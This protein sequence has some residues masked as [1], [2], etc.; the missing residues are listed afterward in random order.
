MD[1]R[2]TTIATLCLL[3]LSGATAHAAPR[4]DGQLEINVVDKDSGQPIAARV[5]LQNARKRPVQLNLPNT[6]E[7][8]DHFYI[9]G[10]LTLPMHRGQY[11]FEIDAGPEYRTQAGHFE[12]ERHADDVKQIKMTRFADLAKE[13]WFA[14]DLDFERKPHDLPLIFRAEHLQDVRSVDFARLLSD[15]PERSAI[16]NPKSE[17]QIAPTPFAWRL[18]AWLASGELDAI[19]LIHRHSLREKVVDNEGDGRPRDRDLFPGRAGNGRWS[20]T[21]YYH[22]LNCGLRMPPVAG[23]GSGFNDSPVGMNRVYVYC[24]EEFS[25]EAWWDGLREGRVFVTNG[26]LLRPSVDG[27]APGYVFHIDDEERLSLEIG[28]NL[29]TRLPVEYLEI[30]QNGELYTDVRL[31][32]W[33]QKKDRLPPVEFDDSGWFL[34]RAVTSNPRVYQFASS[35]PYYVEKAG[36]P[37]VS[38]ASVQFFLDWTRAAEAHFRELPKLDAATREAL[39]AE[40]AT[41]RR[42][43]ENL[44]SSANAD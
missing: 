5:H 15:L 30:I 2:F 21:I 27:Q 31:S 7:F 10:G 12:I 38:R 23:S 32:D 29:A 11:T 20:A 1:C 44:L 33:K 16:H 17:I 26:P 6:G 37:R 41:A 40:Q 18:P 35:G 43:F 19:N 4:A 14:A 34:V 8:A 24:G 39:I 28:L 25:P 36:R 9:N 22:I 3:S 13:G 42:F